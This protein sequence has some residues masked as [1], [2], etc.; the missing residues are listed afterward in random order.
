LF[1]SSLIFGTR[2]SAGPGGRGC[3]QFTALPS[4]W[5]GPGPRLSR[6]ESAC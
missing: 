3:G 1:V 6:T 5:A 4:L 2:A